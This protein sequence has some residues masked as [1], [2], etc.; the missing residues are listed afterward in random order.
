MDAPRPGGDLPPDAA[1][2]GELD[3][4]GERLR[5][6]RPKLSGEALARVRATMDAELARLASAGAAH[7]RG[8]LVPF[9]L[10]LALFV[11]IAVIWLGLGPRFEARQ[12]V[13][14][15]L[16]PDGGHADP[17]A[18]TEALRQRNKLL[19]NFEATDD[20]KARLALAGELR[21]FGG[22]EFLPEKVRYWAA[23]GLL[24]AHLEWHAPYAI[25]AEK[26]TGP[27]PRNIDTQKPDEEWTEAH[28]GEEWMQA[29]LPVE[30]RQP[31]KL[32]PAAPNAKP[33]NSRAY[34]TLKEGAQTDVAQ[35][36]A[37]LNSIRQSS[38]L[39]E[40]ARDWSS[41]LACNNTKV[42]IDVLGSYAKGQPA[43]VVFDVRASSA[44]SFKLYRLH[45][46]R[47]LRELC[48]RIGRDFLVLN[49]AAADPEQHSA[50][51]TWRD[52]PDRK[53]TKSLSALR[54]LPDYPAA[55]LLG[56]W[57][58]RM[59]DLKTVPKPGHLGDDL[60]KNPELT[61]ESKER[62]FFD[63]ACLQFR[64]RIERKYWL[65]PET[66]W[67]RG[68][69]PDEA[70]TTWQCGRIFTLPGDALKESGAYVLVA[71]ANGQR[72]AA[73]I[74]VDALMLSLR[75]SRE[76][77]AVLACDA[78]GKLPLA[79]ADVLADLDL[80]PVKTGNAGL[81]FL[82]TFAEGS[83]AFIIQKEGRFG[84]SGFGRLFDGVNH[85]TL[86]WPQLPN[87]K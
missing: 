23:M 72:F 19:A 3:A 41:A 56:T 48:L 12:Q 69:T 53:N 25:L 36:L 29:R 39:A 67:R 79:G 76:G 66:L 57:Q 11:G 71:E 15:I 85:P 16:E 86:P 35:A 80:A 87:E 30:Q 43:Q 10:A 28:T 32:S 55:D 60:G 34:W 49:H 44:V 73:P 13:Q 22:A 81:A 42:T 78:T 47:P 50:E 75:R 77:A 18:S 46:A 74:L 8:W 59:V 9:A 14:P 26:S 64:D 84:V 2:A 37:L 21:G 51:Q 1:E 5:R 58:V 45:D 6:A 20:P 82:R 40:K 52:V 68:L 54:K 62:E 61:P 27:A 63:D 7:R 4:F 17:S 65:T 70:W 33:V 31:V 24:E 83:R 38:G